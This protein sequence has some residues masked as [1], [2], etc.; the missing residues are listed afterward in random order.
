MRKQELEKL[1][2]ETAAGAPRMMEMHRETRS[3]LG[4]IRAFFRL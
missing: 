3:I 4:K 1:R 2:A